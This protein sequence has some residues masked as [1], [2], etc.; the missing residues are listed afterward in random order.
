[1]VFIKENATVLN[2][3]APLCAK[4]EYRSRKLRV[5]DGN[6]APREKLRKKGGEIFFLGK[7]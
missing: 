7:F 3:V 1:M 2:L 4:S 6:S 5:F